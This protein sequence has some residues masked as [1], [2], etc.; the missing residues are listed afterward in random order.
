MQIQEVSED[1]ISKASTALYSKNCI[2]TSVSTRRPYQP[3]TPKA[4]RD[5]CAANARNGRWTLTEHLRFLEA[6]KLH[7][8]NWKQI[9][10]HIGTRTSTQA[11]S[12]A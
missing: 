12:H 3:K 1:S 8:K 11:R 5:G 2:A 6:L 10:E 9:E 4:G 7:G